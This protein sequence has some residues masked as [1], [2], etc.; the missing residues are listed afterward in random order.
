MTNL[1][2][3]LIA[4]TGSAVAVIAWTTALWLLGDTHR[5]QAT[6]VIEEQVD[7]LIQL[8][9]LKLILISVIAVVTIGLAFV[10][11]NVNHDVHQ[12]LGH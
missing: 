2:L 8:A 11:N 3:G 10:I 5:P 6:N 9:R 12:L 4:F 1:T 7:R